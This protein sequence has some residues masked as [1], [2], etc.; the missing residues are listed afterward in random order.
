M[1]NPAEQYPEKVEFTFTLNVPQRQTP[2][3]I[4]A[5]ISRSI[6]HAS[7]SRV[8]RAIERG[9]VT[10]NGKPTKSNYKIRPGDVIHVLVRKPPPLELIPENIPLDILFE[11]EHLIVIKIGRAHV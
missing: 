1:K 2:E 4:D 3:R 10:V 11:D 6:E 9:T 8:Q 5:F 7:R